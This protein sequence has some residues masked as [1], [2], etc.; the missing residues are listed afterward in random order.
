MT[1]VSSEILILAYMPALGYAVHMTPVH[2]ALHRAGYKVIV[3]TAGLN[4]DLLRHSPH[5][6]HLLKTPNPMHDLPGAVRSL[7]RQLR[8]L[9]LHPEAVL[10]GPQDARTRI[11][12]LGA[13]ASGG[14]R[15]G[16][17]VHPWLY[18]KPLI[19]DPGRSR[20]ANNLRLAEL[21]D[22]STESCEPRVFF[23]AAQAATAAT[24]LPAGRPILTAIPGNSGGLPT[25][26]HDD[27]WAEVLRHMHDQAG[28]K[29]V[30]VGAARD[31]PV[32][33]R[34]RALSGGIGTSLAGLTDLGTL[35]AVLAQSDLCLALHT[36]PMHMARAVGLPT[37]VLGMNWDPPLE[38]MDPPQ[39][40]VHLL[41]G[42]Q[43]AKRPD[44]R[45]DDLTP[46][47]AIAALT[48]LAQQHPPSAEAREKRL[49]GSISRVNH[50]PP[51]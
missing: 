19:Y 11:S 13:L 20:V 10:T 51:S 43:A 24:L 4:I 35:A 14:W 22:A 28:Y 47:M 38:W 50:T 41:R 16:Y 12:L 49:V 36:G 48:T 46:T 26:W 45:L 33:D 6:D 29:I 31:Q 5:V 3:A 40:H 25:A 21:L 27:R 39:A 18:R 2:E 32:V 15:G 34:I 7:R 23:S 8:T 30:F 37:V 44:Y 17:A 1:K 42:P 9:N